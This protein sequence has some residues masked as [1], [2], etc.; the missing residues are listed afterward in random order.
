ME[1]FSIETIQMNESDDESNRIWSPDKI[2]WE[3]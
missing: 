3:S 1:I 2:L